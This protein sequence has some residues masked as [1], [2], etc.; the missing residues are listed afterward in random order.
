MRYLCCD[1]I[2]SWFV[3]FSAFGAAFFELALDGFEGE[4]NGFFEAVGGLGGDDVFE[5]RGDDLDDG[6]FV[7]CGLGFD[8]FEGYVDICDCVVAAG[9]TLGFLVD[10]FDEA[11]GDVEVD[12]LNFNFHNLKF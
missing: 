1:D 12:G 7:H 11:V 10:E 4:V 6:L 9:E 8:D 3:C 2:A 5:L